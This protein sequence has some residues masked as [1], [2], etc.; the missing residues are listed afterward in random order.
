MNTTTTDCKLQMPAELKTRWLEALRSGDYKQS[1][2]FLCVTQDESEGGG[3]KDKEGHEPGYCCLG[4]LA[5]IV[6]NGKP[7][8][9]GNDD[10]SLPSDAWY[11]KNGM[12]SFFAMETPDTTGY[13]EPG[14]GMY[15]KRNDSELF[16]RND[17]YNKYEV[18]SEGYKRIKASVPGVSFLEIADYIEQNVKGV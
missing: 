16:L 13:D 10:Q 2:N 14:H 11:R 18:N 17:G 9:A 15:L 8:K 12:E 3:M 6:E 4:V 1:Q 5:D 7:N